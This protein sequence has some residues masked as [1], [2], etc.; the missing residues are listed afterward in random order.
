MFILITLVIL[1]NLQ[2]IQQLAKCM[3]MCRLPMT[4]D[5]LHQFYLLAFLREL[6]TFFLQ[7]TSTLPK[8]EIKNNALAHLEGTEVRE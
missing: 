8:F 2:S 5:V 7:I 4:R 3:Y 6:I 1:I